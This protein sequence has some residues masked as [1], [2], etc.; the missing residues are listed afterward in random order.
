MTRGRAERGRDRSRPHAV[1]VDNNE[2]AVVKSLNNAVILRRQLDSSE[3][4]VKSFKIVGIYL[5]LMTPVQQVQMTQDKHGNT[6]VDVNHTLNSMYREA[7]VAGG[8]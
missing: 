6:V 2:S 3:M 1:G 8:T 4:F 5:H 7:T